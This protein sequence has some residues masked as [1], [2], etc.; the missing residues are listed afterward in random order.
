MAYLDGLVPGARNQ[1]GALVG[2]LSVV[3]GNSFI[4]CIGGIALTPGD[5]LHDVIML[6]KFGLKVGWSLL[7]LSQYTLGCK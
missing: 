6:S 3:S 7:K 5:A 1:E 4:H 2:W